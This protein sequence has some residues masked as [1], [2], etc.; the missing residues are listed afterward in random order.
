MEIYADDYQAI[1]N[2]TP[3]A[4]IISNAEGKIILA[5]QQV[6][7]LLGYCA[8]ELIGMPIDFLVPPDK[9]GD[10]PQKREEFAEKKH[11]YNEMGVGRSVQALKKDGSL[12]SVEI[13]LSAIK[14]KHGI[15]F[16]SALRDM[17]Q[18]QKMEIAL[19]ESEECFRRV[20]NTS[21]IMI[22]LTD[23][24]GNP[25]FVNEAWLDF[26]GVTAKNAL[27][28]ET[29]LQTIHIDDRKNAFADFYQDPDSKSPI[30]TEYRLKNAEGVWRWVLD[31]SVPFHNQEGVFCGYIGSAID[32]TERKQEEAQLRVA[33][34]AFESQEALVVTDAK[35]TIL[36]VNQAFTEITGYTPE[37]A[38]GQKVSMLKSGRHDDQFYRTMWNTLESEGKWKGEI[39]DRRK[40]GEVYPKWL[41]ITAV[42][43]NHSEITHYV[44]SQTDISERKLAEEKIKFLA[45]YDPLTQLPNRR[46][47][48]ERLTHGINVEKRSGK[49][50]ALMMLDLD[51]FKHINDSY[52]HLAGDELL[53]QVA[54]RFKNRIRE[55]DMVAR[56]G[57]DEFVILLNE[58]NTPEDA[59]RVSHDIIEDLNKPFNLT[60]ANNV[61]TGTSIGISL[62]PEHGGTPEELMDNA[63][64]AL[65]KAKQSGRGC[66]AYFS[67][68]L[69]T[70]AR[71]LVTFEKRLANAIENCQLR[72]FYQ[73]QVDI[74]TGK[75]I[76]AEALV[77]WLDPE[78][79]LI[80]PLH[81]IPLAEETGL[82]THIGEFV[83]FETCRQGKEWIDKGFEPISLAVNVSPHQFRRTEIDKLV[84]EVLE[85]T[86]F[87]PELLE[88]EIT[89]S[90]LMDQKKATDI[91][92]KLRDQKI[93][94]AIDDFGT[95]YSSLAY[96]KHFPVDV[97]KI[98][99]SFIDDIPHLKDDMEIAATIISMGLNLGFKVLA[100]GVETHEQLE[101][102]KRKGCSTYQGY[103][104]SPPIP[105]DKFERLLGSI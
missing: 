85:K 90:G 18:R 61:L 43:N 20:A 79:G 62:Y 82:I 77:R 73:P 42:K 57:G 53:Q 54:Q 87:P 98:D 15:I 30:T 76:G 103:L 24:K 59:A 46:L 19:R 104:V 40:N 71:E 56:L 38:V 63:D 16:A 93:R 26:T 2:A 66:F 80:P 23:A 28:Y 12:V 36:L 25:T 60:K 72:V 11:R 44:S 94:L 67:E 48:H 41:S 6:Q 13:N 96:L 86:Q 22:W 100:E 65:Y 31:K 32:I 4:L 99:K 97:L 95:G 92:K 14:T 102:L 51:K 29:W 75:I 68:E 83:L 5:N 74:L 35:S 49:K 8:K 10:H 70:A 81:F 3:D 88:L 50:M 91:L 34:A 69:T 58:I 47:L 37:E 101:F 7:N 39:W 78:K 89:E 9:R 105:A 52:G 17:T 55:V 27:T 64:I 45:F 1:F 21:P 84:M 33:A